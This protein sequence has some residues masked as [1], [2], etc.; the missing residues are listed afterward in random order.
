MLLTAAV[1][2]L[3]FAAA[4]P[5]GPA[6][7][8]KEVYSRHFAHEQ[9]FDRSLEKVRDHFAPTL[10]ALLDADARAAAAAPGEIVGLDFDPL[11]FAQQEADGWSTGA[12][13]IDGAT[14]RVPVE[15]R[16]GAERVRLTVHLANA[17]GR[18]RISDLDYGE[19]TLAKALRQ[20]AAERQRH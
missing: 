9:R 12:A 14:A 8:V 18:W 15:L 4:A 16:T 6:E 13:A 2:A 20:L 11:V 17:G 7:V 19:T 1:F 3:A 10:L 5:A